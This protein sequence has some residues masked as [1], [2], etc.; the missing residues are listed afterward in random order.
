MSSKLPGYDEQAVCP[1]NKCHVILKSR[2]QKHLINCA[3]QY[4]EIKLDTCPFDITHKYRP[5]EKNV[6]FS[7]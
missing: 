4:P 6:K 5:E 1:Y 7:M 3:K 2:L